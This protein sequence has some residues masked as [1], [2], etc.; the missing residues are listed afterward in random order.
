MPSGAEVIRRPDK[1]SAFIVA[2]TALHIGY[3][4]LFLTGTLPV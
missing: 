2:H 1:N 3:E 4:E